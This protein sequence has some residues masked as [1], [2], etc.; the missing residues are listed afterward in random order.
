MGARQGVLVGAASQLTTFSSAF[1]VLLLTVH[2]RLLIPARF[3]LTTYFSTCCCQ[4]PTRYSWQTPAGEEA[5]LAQVMGTMR[6]HDTLAYHDADGDGAISP[7]ELYRSTAAWNVVRHKVAATQ[8]VMN[9]IARVQGK[10]GSAP[11]M[12]KAVEQLIA[13]ELGYN[14]KF[15]RGV[16]MDEAALRAKARAYAQAG[17]PSSVNREGDPE[18]GASLPM[19]REALAAFGAADHEGGADAEDDGGSE[20]RDEEGEYEH[21]EDGETPKDEL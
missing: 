21:D 7:E 1:L 11:A 19:L 2:S 9:G 5:Q 4:P 14:R 18:A 13:L 12:A 10:H 8:S 6:A 15:R 17:F 16:E 20:Q 3:P